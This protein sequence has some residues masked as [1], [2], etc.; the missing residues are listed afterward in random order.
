[1]AGMNAVTV[2]VM[3]ESP[4]TNLEEVKQ[5]VQ[6]KL[7]KAANI[8]FEEKDIAFGLKALVLTL[9]WPESENTDEIENTISEIQGVS[10]AKI[11]DIRRAFG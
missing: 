3:P 5:K 7:T 11:E 4:D 1:M 6:D 8:Q 10:S 9:A 2:Q